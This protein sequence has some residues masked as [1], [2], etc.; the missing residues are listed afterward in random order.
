MVPSAHHYHPLLTLTINL[1][2]DHVDMLQS[3]DASSTTPPS[4]VFY[5]ARNI[6]SPSF[7]IGQIPDLLDLLAVV[8]T[9]RR[10]AALKSDAAL[11]W[12]KYY[13]H[14]KSHGREEDVRLL[15]ANEVRALRRFVVQKD[16]QRR[17]YIVLI[18]CLILLVSRSPHLIIRIHC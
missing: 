3:P 1:L 10:F 14:E 4:L 17:E 8:E 15:A 13:E 5:A 7:I 16:A 18:R 11:E 6:L 12:Q 9:F 2:S